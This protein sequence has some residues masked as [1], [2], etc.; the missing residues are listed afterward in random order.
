LRTYLHAA[1]VIGPGLFSLAG[2]GAT[3][4][5]DASDRFRGAARI[6]LPTAPR[7]G[8]VVSAPPLAQR[9]AGVNGPKGGRI[10]DMSQSPAIPSANGQIWMHRPEMDLKRKSIKHVHLDPNAPPPPIHYERQVDI[11]A[12]SLRRRPARHRPPATQGGEMV[13]LPDNLVRPL[14]ADPIQISYLL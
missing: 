12:S 7:L 10:A 9:H 8:R 3:P 11:H 5:S 4:A 13:H 1:P 6:C 14:P 2:P